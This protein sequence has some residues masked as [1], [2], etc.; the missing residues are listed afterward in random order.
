MS[1]AIGSVGS[2]T[3]N[4]VCI[5]GTT[6][7]NGSQT[8]LNDASS[9]LTIDSTTQIIMCSIAGGILISIIIIGTGL[10]IYITKK[11]QLAKFKL[12]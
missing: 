8:N 12:N 7:V 3:V 5:K 4:P 6:P 2:I 11:R 1:T 10:G 9:S